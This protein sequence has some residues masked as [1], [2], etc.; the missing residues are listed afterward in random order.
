MPQ[1]WLWGRFLLNW[2]LLLLLHSLTLQVQTTWHVKASW[3]KQ[4]SLMQTRHMVFDA[5]WSDA[6]TASPCG[7]PEQS[8]GNLDLNSAFTTFQWLMVILMTVW[9]EL[10]WVLI[11]E[12]W[13]LL[14]W[15]G[16]NV[17][18]YKWHLRMAHGS[19]FSSLLHQLPFVVSMMAT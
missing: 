18:C 16:Q 11:Q 14:F 19:H 1:N 15:G 8:G 12:A 2:K 3:E 6:H 4:W 17:C 13:E 7:V 10:S 5:V 9:F